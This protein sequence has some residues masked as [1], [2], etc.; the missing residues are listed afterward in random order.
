[1]LQYCIILLINRI[2]P[3]GVIEQRRRDVGGEELVAG[4]TGCL[5]V[6]L[7]SLWAGWLAFM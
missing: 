6:E 2:C 1:M 5:C 7:T 4:G 3:G